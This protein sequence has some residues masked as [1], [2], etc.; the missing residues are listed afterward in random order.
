[1]SDEKAL[2]SSEN[3]RGKSKKFIWILLCAL[4]LVAGT[5]AA[6]FLLNGKDDLSA[7]VIRLIERDGT[8]ALQDEKGSD[9]ELL[10]NMRLSGGSILSTGA[11]GLLKLDMDTTRILTMVENSRL[12]IHKDG[13]ALTLDLLGGNLLFNVTEHLNDDESFDIRTS[14]MMVGIR[15]T[16]AWVDADAEEVFLL[17]GMLHIIGTN[18]K[19]GATKEIDIQA[20]QHVKV[21]LFDDKDGDDSV[22]F[23]VEDVQPHDL[24]E[25]LRQVLREDTDL[26]SLRERVLQDTGWQPDDFDD[27]LFPEGAPWHDGNDSDEVTKA[28]IDG[29]DLTCVI[30]WLIDGTVMKGADYPDSYKPGVGLSGFPSPVREGFTFD[31][32]YLD[33]ELTVSAAAIA[34]DEEGDLTFY[35]TWISDG[36][37]VGETYS[38]LYTVTGLKSFS[39]GDFQLVTSYVSG[40]ETALVKP[41]KPG[42]TFDG[43][44]ED[45]A[46]KKAA[47]AISGEQ[48]GNVR[49]YGRFIPHEYRISYTVDGIG[50][51]DAAGYGMPMTYKVGSE[52]DIP[53]PSIWGYDFYGWYRDNT[54]KEAVSYIPAE[55]IGDIGLYGIA[56]KAEDDDDDEDEVVVSNIHYVVE[57]FADFDPSDYACPL[58]YT[59]GVGS[60]LTIP[61]ITGHTFDGWYADAGMTTAITEIAATMTGNVTVYGS[62]TNNTYAISYDVTGVNHFDAAAYNLPVEYTYGTASS[63]TAPVITG[64]DFAGW[65]S[66]TGRT[67]AITEIPATQTG[68]LTLYGTVTAHTHTITYYAT[69]YQLQQAASAPADMNL[70]GAATPKIG[71]VEVPVEFTY[72]ETDTALPALS[73]V[74]WV[75]AGAGYEPTLF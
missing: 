8:V 49:L 21:F 74:G 22:A 58:T 40:E 59:E 46:M 69:T 34:K 7:V 32:W 54:M 15:G 55:T 35:G 62:V 33:P 66:D 68:D 24:P 41:E 26:E 39:V 43:W 36:D 10:D 25:R 2:Q 17:D 11:D 6:I 28:P 53:S 9:R 16:S 72:S 37:A 75:A 57:G 14:N 31:G 13:K 12:E 19:T 73:Y 71:D 52:I 60:G 3:E 18:P 45:E 64:H 51:F 65:Y 47:S 70:A 20:G 56:V 44:Y 48:V 38:V 23:F 1:M 63:L 27:W 5:L 61:A 29:G 67:V 50:S 4:L 42:Y 30:T